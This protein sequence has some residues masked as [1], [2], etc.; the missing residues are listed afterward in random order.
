MW[1][2][3]SAT[4]ISSTH[5]WGGR[6][7]GHRASY[8]RLRLKVSV[9]HWDREDV[10]CERLCPQL[11]CLWLSLVRKGLSEQ[12]EKARKEGVSRTFSQIPESPLSL[13]RCAWLVVFWSWAG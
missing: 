4:P 2:C 9:S 13:L 7:E 1:C 3:L 10:F 5:P 12:E 8:L 11:F 6:G